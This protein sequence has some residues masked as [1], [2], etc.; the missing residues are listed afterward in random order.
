MASAQANLSMI[1]GYVN[2]YGPITILIIG[3]PGC[4]SSLITFT[5]PRLRHNSCAF[6]YLMATF[7]ELIC[8]TYG[9]ITTYA[10]TLFGVRP[11]SA[12]RVYCKIHAYLIYSIPLIATYMVLL[13]SIDRYLSSSLR[14][15]LRNYSQVK[16][17]Y[18]ASAVAILF[19]LVSC[20][21]TL[22]SYD[23]RPTCKTIPGTYATVDSIWV[24]CWMGVIPHVLMLVFGSLTIH[25]IRTS[26]RR[27]HSEPPRSTQIVD[28]NQIR[29]RK[30]N[31]QL[32]AVSNGIHVSVAE[33]FMK[34]T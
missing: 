25:N 21:H 26:K 29:E 13:A 19:G 15:S 3:I 8:I 24:V 27:L 20:S 11:S 31:R 33:F 28:Q 23:L 34:S 14:V 9:L 1:N 16:I 5:A 18:R 2:Y 17:A 30:T 22:V 32:I 6:Y 10:L 12:D 7:F 4:L